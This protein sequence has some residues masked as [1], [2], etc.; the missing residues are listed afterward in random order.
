MMAS[1]YFRLQFRRGRHETSEALGKHKQKSHRA[2]RADSK[3]DLQDSRARGCNDYRFE[4]AGGADSPSKLCHDS[5][6]L[7][8]VVYPSR[9]ATKR[10][11]RLSQVCRRT[12]MRTTSGC[13]VASQR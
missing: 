13:K 2:L 9:N 3:R 12:V 11:R 6:S 8:D 7:Y 4:A 1:E 10:F 5:C